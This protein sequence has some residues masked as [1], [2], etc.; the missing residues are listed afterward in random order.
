MELSIIIPAYNEADRL[1]QTLSR[2]G[3][4]LRHSNRSVEVIVVDDGSTDG[5]ADLAAKAGYAVRVIKQTRNM[6]KGAAVRTGML[7]AQ[8]EWRYLCDADLSTPIED[9]EQLWARRHE[10]DIILGSRRVSGSQITK[11]QSYL[12]ETIGR[13]GNLLIQLLIA[14]GI[15]DT[16]C[17]FK[18][19]SRRTVPLFEQQ[20]IQ[21]WGYDFELLYL[22]RMIGM[23]IIEVPV[24]WTNDERSKVKS[25]DYF[26]TLFELVTIFYNRLRGYY[27]FS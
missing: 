21:R 5:T 7:A 9:L 1:P 15:H 2:I 4:H 25:T 16:Q 8:G 3:D 12:K 27:K 11:H 26:T 24:R 20:R 23:K 19:F 22:A 13:G 14:P 6:G 17:G 10:A 18:L